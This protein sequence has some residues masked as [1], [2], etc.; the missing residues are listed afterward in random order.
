MKH[1]NKDIGILD[2]NGVKIQNG[3]NVLVHHFNSFPKQP[4]KC[5]VVYKYGWKLK[6][7]K[8]VEGNDYDIYAWRKSIEVIKTDNI[9]LYDFS[10]YTELKDVW[11]IK[12]APFTIVGEQRLLLKKCFE[13]AFKLGQE[14]VIT[15]KL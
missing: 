9:S 2:K 10:N 4:Y 8:G 6:S 7:D 5:T 1:K 12:N 14:E 15:K 11:F 3:D 13:D